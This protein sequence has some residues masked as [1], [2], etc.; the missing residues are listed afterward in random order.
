[1]QNK[2]NKRC[3]QIYGFD[4]KPKKPEYKTFSLF[5][6]DTSQIKRHLAKINPM[7]NVVAVYPDIK[8]PNAEI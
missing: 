1:M 8:Y 6:F 2:L 5:G 3:F 4:Y 7:F